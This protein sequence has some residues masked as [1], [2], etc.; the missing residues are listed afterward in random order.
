[1]VSDLACKKGITFCMLAIDQ[2]NKPG[3]ISADHHPAHF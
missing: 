1:M 2:V 3:Q